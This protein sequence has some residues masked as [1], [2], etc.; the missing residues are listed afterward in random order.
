MSFPESTSFSLTTLA[1]ITAKHKDTE[2]SRVPAAPSGAED[3]E[4]AAARRQARGPQTPAAPGPH[5]SWGAGSEVTPR[6]LVPGLF[7]ENP[8]WTGARAE[9][10]PA[11]GD[12]H[13][14]APGPKGALRPR[15]SSSLL[16]TVPVRWP[17]EPTSDWVASI[18][19]TRLR[20]LAS[21]PRA[22]HPQP[23][24]KRRFR[25][26]AE[27]KGPSGLGL[28]SPASQRSILLHSST[29]LK[30]SPENVLRMSLGKNTNSFRVTAEQGSERFNPKDIVSG[31]VAFAWSPK[32]QTPRREAT[33][34][35]R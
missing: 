32:G 35:G 21:A 15:N 3:G 19:T 13:L 7:K 12:R 6:V 2:V 18:P 22:L 20:M 14:A 5:A 31:E 26:K 10:A 9:T 4:G 28:G 1:L 23:P 24:G 29:V 33:R 25:P 17:G 8:L 30:V 11:P 27:G 16:S 34:E